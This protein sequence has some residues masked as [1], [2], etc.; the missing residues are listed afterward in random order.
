MLRLPALSLR[1]TFYKAYLLLTDICN[2]VGWDE[3]LK[4]RSVSF[5]ME[6][7]YRAQRS[8]AE[9]NGTSNDSDEDELDEKP[10]APPM[11]E[12]DD[13]EEDSLPV[14]MENI[15]LDSKPIQNLP[16]NDETSSSSSTTPKELSPT[17]SIDILVNG[18]ISMLQQTNIKEEQ[19]EDVNDLPPKVNLFILFYLIHCRS[20]NQ[21]R[22]LLHWPPKDYAKN[23]WTI[24]SWFY[25]TTYDYILPLNKNLLITKILKETVKLV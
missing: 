24:Y 6:E 8:S 11:I 19:E 15:S 17:K 1:G 13:N 2:K 25:T 18:D 16:L 3:L 7:E 20:R 12:P 14:A 21:L 4:H 10:N 5:V 22:N 9:R 23:G